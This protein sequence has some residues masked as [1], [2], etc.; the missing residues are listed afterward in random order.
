M[1][2]LSTRNSQVSYTAARVLSE[3]RAPDGG[4]F[5]PYY[6]A[7]FPKEELES[8]SCRKCNEVIARLL[9]IQFQTR[10][11]EH[12]VR[13]CLGH[14]PVRIR[15][16]NNRLL[17]G[18][19][20]HNLDGTFS[21]LVENLAR[22]LGPEAAAQKGSW[23][24][25]GVGI[26]VLF[27]IFAE[28]M[29]RGLASE[30]KKVDISVVSGDFSIVLACWYA[31]T[32]GLPLG[33]IVCC[34]NENN[35]LWHLF[36]GGQLRTDGVSIPTQT[37]EADVCVPESLERLIF[38]LGGQQETEK[39]VDCV[40]RGVSYYPEEGMLSKLRQ[41]MYVSVV[42]S[43][44]MV[45]TIPNAYTTHGYLLSPYSALAYAGLMDF[46]AKNGGARTGLVLAGYSPLSQCEAVAQALG[47]SPEDLKREF[48]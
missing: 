2:Y 7:P 25:T 33:N 8:L 23:T 17:V 45:N 34:C 42:S 4:L 1:L 29:A 36:A 46:R 22:Q 24:H 15:G 6:T 47:I 30:E 28:L 13:L 44:R 40:H 14:S 38:A 27:G 19:C 37:P 39:Y 10:L 43:R 41:G 26:A 32:W 16:L 12:D 5:V 48:E 18:E 21:R 31:R 35:G 9:N 20:W 11:T 3:T